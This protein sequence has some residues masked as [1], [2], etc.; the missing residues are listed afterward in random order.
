MQFQQLNAQRPYKMPATN[1]IHQSFSNTQQF[2]MSYREGV[3][4]PQNKEV[5]AQSHRVS[6]SQMF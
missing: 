2:H 5:L 1:N 3:P 6:T 4:R